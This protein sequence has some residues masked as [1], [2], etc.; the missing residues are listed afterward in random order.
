MRNKFLLGSILSGI[1]AAGYVFSYNVGVADAGGPKNLKVFPKNISK[2]ELKKEMKAIAKSLGVQCD[3]CHDMDGMDKDT[4]KKK[5]ALA[6][7]RMT[8]SANQQLKKAGFKDKV[9]C[10]TCHRGKETPAK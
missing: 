3:F 7:L 2:K 8:K 4:E 10:N 9:T 5:A 6:M 1:L